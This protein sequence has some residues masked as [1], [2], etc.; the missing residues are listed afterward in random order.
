MPLLKSSHWLP[1]HYCTIFLKICTIAYQTLSSTQP[2]YLNL[3]LTPARNSTHLCSASSNPLYIHRVKTK[4]GTR[5]FS[6]HSTDILKPISLMLPI[7]LSLLASSSS[8][9]RLTHCF[10]LRVC[11]IPWFCRTSDLELRGYWC[12]RSHYYYY[13]III[14]SYQLPMFF[15]RSHRVVGYGRQLWM[16][17]YCFPASPGRHRQH[18]DM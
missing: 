7:L 1:V 12:K 14:Y 6:F 17:K 11:L 10:R 5:A 18:A 4:A 3:I 16:H 15:E 8:H 2:A 9:W 13:Y